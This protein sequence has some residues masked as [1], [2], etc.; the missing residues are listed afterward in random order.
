[1]QKISGILHSNDGI[2]PYNPP[3]KV[4][5]ATRSDQIVYKKDGVDKEMMYLALCDSTGYI[6]ATLYEPSKI[7]KFANGS[8]I[9]IRNYLVRNDKTMAITS[10]SQIFK[11][12]HLEVP[13][14]ILNQAI[15]SVRPPTPPRV[16]IKEV[17]TS[18]VKTL[19]SVGGVIAQVR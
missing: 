13:E 8:T 10:H 4:V 19:T 1:M 7:E 2:K 6:K 14:S 12:S 15:S 16:P 5:L 17:H 3:I 11:S 18:P 9:M